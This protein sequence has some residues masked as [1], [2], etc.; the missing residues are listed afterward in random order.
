VTAAPLPQ[1]IPMNP[2]QIGLVSSIFTLGGLVGALAVGPLSAR[3]G[4]LLVMRIDT[5]FFALGPVAE[6][7]A[8]NVGVM[9]FGRFI[10]GL[11]A[12]ASLVVVPIYISEI[13]PPK[14][15]G[16]FGSFTQIMTNMGILTTQLLGLFWSH[17]QMWRLILAVAGV[18][19]VI[20]F[21]GLLLAVESPKWQADHGKPRKAKA[22]LQ[23]IR[24]HKADIQEEYESW[25]TPTEDE[26]SGTLRICPDY[27]YLNTDSDQRR[28]KRYS[29]ITITCLTRLI[30]P[31]R[32]S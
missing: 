22:N 23:R 30:L 24:G 4:R 2:A 6:A 29:A 32:S 16:F 17:G 27:C 18:I 21:L 19:G 31:A 15:K 11:G 10:S 14:E 7:L 25:R 13:A 28:R 12:G 9:A 26:R 5:L 1:C 3:C 20:Q 8:P